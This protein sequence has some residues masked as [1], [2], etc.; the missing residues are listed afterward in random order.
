MSQT[1]REKKEK[2]EL[3]DAMRAA[4]LTANSTIFVARRKPAGVSD[5]RWRMELRRRMNPA[6]YA[7]AANVH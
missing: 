3:T 4:T 2:H 1:Y 5:I 7:F 6:R